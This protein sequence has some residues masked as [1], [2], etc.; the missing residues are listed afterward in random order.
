MKWKLHRNR[1]HMSIVVD[2]KVA[3][4]S[5]IFSNFNTEKN[6]YYQNHI[7]VLDLYRHSIANTSSQIFTH[8]YVKKYG[9][10]A[11]YR[12]GI[13]KSMS[14]VDNIFA[15]NYLNFHNFF[16]N[17]GH[18]LFSEPF[19]QGVFEQSV[20]ADIFL[21]NV[22]SAP[23]IPTRTF[24]NIIS[25]LI[26]NP[27]LLGDI[28]DTTRH[29]SYHV[30]MIFSRLY[31]EQIFSIPFLTHL[32]DLKKTHAVV[33]GNLEPDLAGQDP[34]LHW[35]AFEAKGATSESYLYSGMKKAKSQ[36]ASLKS[37]NNDANITLSA[38]GTLYNEKGVR[39]L[40][41]DPEPTGETTITLDWLSAILSH[42]KYINLDFDLFSKADSFPSPHNFI[43]L[44]Y[45]SFSGRPF[46]MSVHTKV[47]NL[48]REIN[49][50]SQ[51]HPLYPEGMNIGKSDKANFSEI[52]MN[53]NY[54]SSHLQIEYNEIIRNLRDIINEIS[55][56]RTFGN[57][58]TSIGLDGLCLQSSNL[59]Y[60]NPL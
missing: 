60:E 49:K 17:A 35:H 39:T 59:I 44:P 3:G 2:F 24:P 18:P 4:Y 21:N 52:I 45:L 14:H 27:F 43:N 58:S 46:R 54:L 34:N 1:S 7:N 51:A 42:Y 20:G 29:N 50:T 22:C 10:K 25:R 36:L 19:L 37:I 57:F 30:G 15:V 12:F 6:R 31:A 53:R 13:A 38:S 55:G 23:H 48:L 40:L 56:D 41:R 32:H 26:K 47:L 11:I 5:G 33:C 28:S 8:T 16:C 9:W